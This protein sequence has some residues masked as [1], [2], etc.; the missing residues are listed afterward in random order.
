MRLPIQTCATPQLPILEGFYVSLQN[1]R[2]PIESQRHLEAQNRVTMAGS[3]TLLLEQ[4][5]RAATR[6]YRDF[7][8]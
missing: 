4:T 1:F 3:H 2:N 6:T 8:E 5:G 7:D